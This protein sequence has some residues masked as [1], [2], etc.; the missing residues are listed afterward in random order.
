MVEHRVPRREHPPELV[1]EL[2]HQEQPRREVEIGAQYQPVHLR[3]HGLVVV[4]EEE[5]VQLLV[6]VLQMDV[7]VRR[8]RLGPHAGGVVGLDLLSTEQVRVAVLAAA[9]ELRQVVDEETRGELPRCGR[10]GLAEQS[11]HV[12]GDV[13]HE[14]AVGEERVEEGG[15]HGEHAVAEVAAAARR[16]DEVG[17]LDEA[18][19]VGGGEL[20][21]GLLVEERA[22]PALAVERL[23]L[24]QPGDEVRRRRV[25]R[26]LAVERRLV[27]AQA[28][29]LA[30][31]RREQP[32]EEPVPVRRGGFRRRPCWILCIDQETSELIA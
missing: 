12:V 30:D 32:A 19:A 7:R 5:L 25:R 14:H 28:R 26:R 13:H 15:R 22:G 10:E 16:P 3:Q 1:L 17:A 27:P 9:A 8:Q 31:V 24:A 11:G 18:H 23:V 21:Q 20:H 29:A 4:A 6:V 2:R